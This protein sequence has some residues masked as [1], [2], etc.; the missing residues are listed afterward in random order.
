MKPAPTPIKPVLAP[1]KPVAPKLP[2]VIPPAAVN[3]LRSAG[4]PRPLPKLVPPNAIPRAPRTAVAVDVRLRHGESNLEVHTRDFSA[5]G[6][7]AVTTATLAVGDVVDCEVRLPAPTGLAEQQFSVRAKVVR[8]ELAGY[9][10]LL[11][12]PPA[13][14]VAALAVLAS[15]TA[16]RPSTSLPRYKET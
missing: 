14:M 9:G 1:I 16:A 12:E 13:P 3:V 11:V 7:F 4:A 15:P 10:M 5:T 2:S 8:R 6:F